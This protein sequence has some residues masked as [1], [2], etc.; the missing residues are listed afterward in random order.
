[1]ATSSDGLPLS[2]GVPTS[3]DAGSSFA[4]LPLDPSRAAGVRRPEPAPLGDMVMLGE[5]S[6]PPA[7]APRR[8]PS[9]WCAS[10]RYQGDDALLHL[11]EDLLDFWHAFRPTRAEQAA[12]NALVKRVRKVVADS[13]HGADVKVFGSF[14]T[15][16][17]LPES[18]IDLVCVNT[19]LEGA[20][21]KQR[22]RALHS[23]AGGLRGASWR[24]SELEVVDTAKVPIVKFVD[25]LTGIAVDVCIE[26]KDGLVSSSLS[27]KA[28]QQFPA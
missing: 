2:Y 20:S 11:H 25:A 26:T 17:Y 19:G 3:L 4:Q 24:V 8:A 10:R 16:L 13:L 7:A 5:S 1:M 28:A 23:L 9:H 12:R 6:L 14:S 21:K 22:A 27:K 18:D 15:G